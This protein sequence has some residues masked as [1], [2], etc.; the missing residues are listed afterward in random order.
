MEWSGQTSGSKNS[1]KYPIVELKWK[2]NKCH[3]ITDF[4]WKTKTKISVK[5]GYLDFGWI[6]NETYVMASFINQ[7]T[8]FLSATTIKKWAFFWYR[9]QIY[10]IM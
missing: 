6:K 3:A 9:L 10:I 4:F 1:V 2:Y 7:N 8:H 5:C